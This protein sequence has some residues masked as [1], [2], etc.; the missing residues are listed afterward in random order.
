MAQI[1]VVS[2]SAHQVRRRAKT[3]R[4][5][6]KLVYHFFVCLLAFVMIYPLLWMVMSSFKPTHTI[7][8]TVEQLIPAQ[9]TTENYVNGWKG[10]SKITFGTFFKNSAVIACVGTVGAT[11]SSALVGYGLSRFRFR[12]RNILFACVLVGMMLPA[13]ILMIPQYLWFQKLNWTGTLAPLL[14]PPFFATQGFFVYLMMNFISG[15]PRDL[16]Q[17]ARIDGCSYYSVFTRIIL[18]LLVP[19]IVTVVIFSFIWK[20][21]DYLGPLIYINKARSFPASIALKVFCDPS[22]SSDY[23]A[24]FAMSG[25]S[26][27]PIFTIFLFFQKYLTEGISTSG[28][29]G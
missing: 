4:L 2:V 27:L 11:V 25:L 16:D 17:A 18:P 15:L 5:A 13:Q 14:V 22:T 10:F 9:F 29:K 1:Q 6:R 24:M 28:L 3:V 20:W 8:Q 12:G 19:A 26:L 7:F 23:G 21:D